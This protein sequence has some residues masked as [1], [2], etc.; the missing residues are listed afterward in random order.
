ML[1]PS[2]SLI[3]PM[4]CC[5]LAKLSQEEAPGGRHQETRL[6]EVHVGCSQA[7]AIVRV[8]AKQQ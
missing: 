5:L 3:S 6:G 8:K 7:S 2:H 1:K 4:F